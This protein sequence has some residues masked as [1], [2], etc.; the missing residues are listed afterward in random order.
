LI[1]HPL[2]DHAG[3]A[4][5][6]RVLERDQSFAKKFAHFAIDLSRPEIVVIQKNLEPRRCFLIVIR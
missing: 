4:L 1:K 5:R 3:L 6:P 2:I